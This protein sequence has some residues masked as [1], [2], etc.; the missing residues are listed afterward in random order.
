MQITIDTNKDST[1]DIKKLIKMLSALV[2]EEA[3]QPAS[4]VSN[5]SAVAFTS[6]FGGAVPE[7][8][9]KKEPMQSIIVDED[10]KDADD[11]NIPEI[12]AY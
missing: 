2:G 4:N 1:E 10:D 3:S 8:E 12:I 11:E 7:S 9:P 5:E 6:M